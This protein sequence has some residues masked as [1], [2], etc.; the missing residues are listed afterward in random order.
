MNFTAP[1]L[2][3]QPLV[4]GF[5]ADFAMNYARCLSDMAHCDIPA[6][7]RYVTMAATAL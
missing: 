2:A 4:A 5:L 3:G 1:L 6:C 7:P